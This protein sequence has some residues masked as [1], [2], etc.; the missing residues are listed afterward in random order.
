MYVD[1]KLSGVK[2]VQTLSRLNRIH[3]GK[4]DTFV[5]DFVNESEDIKNAFMPFYR[6]TVLENDIEPNDIYRAETSI[7]ASQLINKDDVMLFTKIF[8]KNK[9][10]N[11]DRGI[12]ENCVNN[13]INRTKGLSREEL[14]EFKSLLTRFNNLYN[15]I[16]QIAPI[17]DSDLHRLSIYNRFV[18][19]KIDI[20]SPSGV[21]ITDK[22]LL[23]YYKLQKQSEGDIDLNSGEVTGVQVRV[24]DG[25]KAKDEEKDSLTNIIDRLNQ[26]FGTDF[27]ESE[28]L[29]VEQ[30]MNGLKN[31][32]DLKQ[33]AKVNTYDN[34]KHAFEKYFEDIAVKE[35]EK[36]TEFYGRI[37]QDESF[38]RKL[39]DLLMFETYESFKDNE[40]ND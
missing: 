19:K 3:P 4:E 30:I 1:K 37:F 11:A 31:E 24:P 12:M 17:A 25:A 6:K 15:L 14:I 28:K 9:H 34:F 21:D 36:N 8:Y 5:L 22:V 35:Y 38:K 40:V 32:E 16:I 27:S 39:M 26:R 18:I 33:K 20:E 2:A 7:Y 23:E 29:A 10:T 13:T